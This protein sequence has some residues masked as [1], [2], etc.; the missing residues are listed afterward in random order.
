MCFWNICPALVPTGSE[1]RLLLW[2]KEC[3]SSWVCPTGGCKVLL[4]HGE[5]EITAQFNTF[6]HELD[7]NLTRKGSRHI[8]SGMPSASKD[9]KCK[10]GRPWLKNIPATF[11]D[12][13]CVGE[14]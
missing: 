12:P 8:C 7:E 5:E 6:C 9:E 3:G 10:L 11:N 2:V 4:G 1:E 14:S 13:P